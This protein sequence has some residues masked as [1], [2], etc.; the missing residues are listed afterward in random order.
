M[1]VS[2]GVTEITPEDT[3]EAMFE[4]VEYA[5]GQAEQAGP[6]CSFFHNGKEPERIEP[7]NLGADEVEIEL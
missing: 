2:G 5:L 3:V 7:P 1:T 4:R 6:N